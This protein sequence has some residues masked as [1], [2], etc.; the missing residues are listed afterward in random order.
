VT[1]G[2]GSLAIR[3]TRVATEGLERGSAGE[4]ALTTR[5]NDE[6]S[7][8]IRAFPEGWVWMHPRWDPPTA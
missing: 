6:I 4:R 7:A 5:L 1:T 2:T 3:V 8:R